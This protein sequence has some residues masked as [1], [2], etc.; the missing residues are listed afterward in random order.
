MRNHKTEP[1]EITVVEHMYRSATWEITS[2]SIKFD[3]K[4]SQTAEFHVQIPPD[5]EQ[6]VIYNV[7]YTW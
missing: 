7:H 3:K 1:V 4:D 2:S 6:T 5:G